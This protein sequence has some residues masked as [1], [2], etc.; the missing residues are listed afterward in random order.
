MAEHALTVYYDGD[1]EL[2]R[3]VLDGYA[4]ELAEEL[5]DGI[6]RADYPGESERAVRFVAGVRYAADQVDPEVTE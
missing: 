1:A 4:H 6:G 2:A 5:R 3:K